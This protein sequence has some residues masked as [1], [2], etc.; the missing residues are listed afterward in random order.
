MDSKNGRK[1]TIYQYFEVLQIE[2]IVANL[3]SKIYRLAKDKE[4]WNKV[5]ENKKVKIEEIS[6]RNSLPNIFSDSSM[7]EDIERM[8]FNEYTHPNFHYKDEEQKATQ[9]YY[10]LLYYY[11][12][13]AE[14]S[15][16][17]FGEVKVGKIAIYTP[18]EPHCHIVDMKDEAS[19][20]IKV[21]ITSV[22]RIL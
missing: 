1:L 2:Y 10:D 16:N 14:V 22:K 15:Y 9:G 4:Y 3:R 19:T 12:V 7:K 18:F 5:K 13:G 8:I 20:P 11:Y 6:N 17:L 21:D